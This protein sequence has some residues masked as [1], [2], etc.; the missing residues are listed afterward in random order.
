MNKIKYLYRKSRTS[1]NYNSDVLKKFKRIH[2]NDMFSDLPKSEKMKSF[3]YSYNYGNYDITPL[4]EFIKSKIGENWNDIYSEII[5]KTQFKFRMYLDSDIDYIIQ[6]PMYDDDYIPKI[7][8]Y[9]LNSYKMCDDR[10]YIDLNNIICFKSRDEILIDSKN[11]L[12]KL[13]LLEIS[14]IK[15]ES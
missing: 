7:I 12:R 2:N 8:G 10:L 13:K 14:K 4:Q 6:T 3:K 11:Y 1:R 15:K 5:K 9:G